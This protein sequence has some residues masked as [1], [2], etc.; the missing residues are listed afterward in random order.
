MP[1][2]LNAETQKTISDYLDQYCKGLSA[3][4]REALDDG[5]Y[6]LFWASE[7][8]T[9]RDAYDQG[10]SDGYDEGYKEAESQYL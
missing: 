6:D 8:S 9:W 4:D 1:D 3:E 10:S 2:E 5:L 7:Q